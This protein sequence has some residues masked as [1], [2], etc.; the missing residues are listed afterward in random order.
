MGR[1]ATENNFHRR[2]GRSPRPTRLRRVKTRVLPLC[3]LCL[4]APLREIILHLPHGNFCRILDWIA[5]HA[6]RDTGKG[7]GLATVLHRQ[8]RDVTFY[9]LDHFANPFWFFRQ[10]LQDQQDYGNG[11]YGICVLYTSSR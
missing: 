3:D 1:E 11:R 4:S 7:Y 10:E 2:R 6:C 8:R 5:V 9:D